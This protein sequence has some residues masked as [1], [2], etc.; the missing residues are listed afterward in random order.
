MA[1]AGAA[2]SADTR[3][4]NKAR[5]NRKKGHWDASPPVQTLKLPLARGFLLRCGIIWRVC[6]LKKIFGPSLSSFLSILLKRYCC[7]FGAIPEIWTNLAAYNRGCFGSGLCWHLSHVHGQCKQVHGCFCGKE[8]FT[9]A[10]SG[11]Q[12]NRPLIGPCTCFPSERFGTT[13]RVIN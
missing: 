6:W 8:T 3:R 9:I 13:Q 7:I 11:L 2:Q 1:R 5:R 12:F 4:R 10:P